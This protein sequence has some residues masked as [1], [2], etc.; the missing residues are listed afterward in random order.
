MSVLTQKQIADRL[1]VS[2]SLV[3]Q[4]LNGKRTVSS[5]LH[6]RIVQEGERLGYQPNHS[7]QALRTGRRRSWG[8]LVPDFS[9]LA[10]FN[11]QIVQGLSEV[12]SANDHAVSIACLSGPRAEEEDYLKVVR[13]G[14]FDGVFLIY[15]G[16][17]SRPPFERIVRLGAMPVVIN[18][19]LG[20]E[21][22]PHVC[23]D[24]EG[25][26]YEA[27]R[28]LIDVHGRR[29]IAFVNRCRES[30]V[31]EDR[32]RG[33]ERALLD[34]GLAVD[35]ALV[36]PMVEGLSYEGHGERAV[37]RLVETGVEFD[38]IYC[39]ADYIAMGVLAGLHDHGIAVPQRVAVVGFDNF[40]LTACTRP[41][42]T[43]VACDGI[44]M[45]RRAGRMML[46]IL[47]GGHERVARSVRLPVSLVVRESCGC[48][49]AGVSDS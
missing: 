16:R 43:T 30:W 46:E 44:A 8:I 6:R 41:R 47:D 5:K 40:H 17:A 22:V 23:S 24:G 35:D 11:R 7:A 26:V 18:C 13:G 10:D 1:G 37:R 38:A 32:Y 15:E 19:P 20:D 3:S 12:A 9:F 2:Q 31:M 45:G 25:G 48:G 28:H 42:L 39:A 21:A 33:Y 14:R 36:E 34:A 4:I 49:K 29:R 27:V